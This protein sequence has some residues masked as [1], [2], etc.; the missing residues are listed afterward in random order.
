MERIKVQPRPHWE[1][2]LEDQ[3]CLYHSLGGP[4]WSEG[5][6]YR[7]TKREAQELED[8]TNALHEMCLVAAEYVVRT[9]R[10]SQFGIPERY[11]DMIAQSWRAQGPT[12]YGRFDLRYDGTSPP[13]LFEYNADTPTSLLEASRLQK[14]WKADLFGADEQ[15][16]TVEERL[17]GAWRAVA[18]QHPIVHFSSVSGHSEDMGNTVF[19]CD[20]A[21][22]AGID[23]RF[24]HVE[25]VRWNPCERHFET[26]EGER[27]STWFKLYP[28]EW[29]FDD[30]YGD[31]IQSG[32]M[33]C[34]E[35][36]WKVLLS[37]KAILPILWELFPDHPN[38]LPAYFD[39][40]R[41]GSSYVRKP[42]FGREGANISIVQKGEIASSVDGPYGGYPAIYQAVCPLPQFSRMYTLVGSWVIGGTAAGIGVRESVSMISENRSRFLPHVVQ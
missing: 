41:L 11:R 39:P 30:H 36:A 3:G 17:I 2:V 15:F 25:E 35:P 24:L 23:A 10:L 19:M 33:T 29:I 21:R 40:E 34:I 28:W 16:N 8:A 1:L 37:S 7:F 6:G 18:S 31:F 20:M 22:R 13:K 38:L 27:I 42:V 4:Y 26:P 14:R 5:V 32:S 9:D 12:I